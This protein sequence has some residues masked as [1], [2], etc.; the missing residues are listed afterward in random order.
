MN[1]QNKKLDIQDLNVKLMR[2]LCLE[3]FD[4]EEIDARL[5]ALRGH[6]VPSEFLM[7]SG[8]N[9]WGDIK[10][11]LIFGYL[12]HHSHF[13]CVTKLN[14]LGFDGNRSVYF[15][16]ENSGDGDHTNTHLGEVW[17]G[18]RLWKLYT[19]QNHE[20]IHNF[21]VDP[22]NRDLKYSLRVNNC[23]IDLEELESKFT[24]LDPLAYAKL[25]DL[26]HQK[27]HR[28]MGSMQL[29]YKPRPGQPRLPIDVTR[30]IAQEW[31]SGHFGGRRRRRQSVR[32]RRARSRRH[33]RK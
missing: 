16:L 26:S 14:T 27:H 19:R 29:S 20:R 11:S 13:L 3:S 21:F 12:H 17:S 8:L 32:N 1:S 25:L 7:M 31:T 4:T 22:T 6:D 28:L 24:W 33:G 2:T 15:N 18:V 5:V 30:S 9:K 23:F 10:D